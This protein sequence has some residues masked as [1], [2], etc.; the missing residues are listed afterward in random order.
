LLT[1]IPV[2]QSTE[3]LCS[4]NLPV[5]RIVEQ[6]LEQKPSKDTDDYRYFDPKIMRLPER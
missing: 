3:F 4:Q 5:T 1:Y 2:L 6:L